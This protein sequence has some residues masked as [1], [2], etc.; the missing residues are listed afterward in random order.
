MHIVFLADPIDNQNGG[1]HY[2]CVNSLKAILEAN[3]K[4]KI[5]IIKETSKSFHPKANIIARKRNHGLIREFL[6]IPQI[7]KRLNPDIVVEMAHFGPFNLPDSIKRVTVIHDLTPISH[8][9]WHKSQ[10]P[11]AHKIFLPLILKNAHAIITPSVSTC[12]DLYKYYPVSINKTQCIYLGAESMFTPTKDPVFIEKYQLETPYFLHIGTFEPR[13]DHL[14]LLAAYQKYRENKGAV[15]KLIL[16]G[17]T[18]WKSKKIHKAIESHP[19]KNEIEILGFVDRTELP[20]LLTQ[21][22]GFIFPSLYEGFGLPL[23]E[24]MSCGAPCIVSRNSS[25]TEVG[26][27]DAMYFQTGNSKELANKMKKLENPALRN[28]LKKVALK[29]SMNFSWEFHSTAFF[30]LVELL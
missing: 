23:L 18:G 10:S 17:G 6:S 21:C 3:T 7:V 22:H 19:F 24:A 5:T 1:I 11:P 9:Q 26:G 30:K 12:A 8:P 13:K 4:H 16:I 25:L 2:Y 14:T 20:T 27:D 28:S 29:Q 15:K